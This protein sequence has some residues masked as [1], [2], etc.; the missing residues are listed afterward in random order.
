M[1]ERAAITLA[2]HPRLAAHRRL[3]FDKARETWTI[4]APERA[5]MLDEIAHAIVSR[6]DGTATTGDIIDDLCKSF[7]D[8]PRAAIEN[9]V[10]ALLQDFADKGVM[11]L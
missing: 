11:A 4:Q 3:H 9:D 10:L 5:F 8:A 2:S 7:P 6:C 1:S